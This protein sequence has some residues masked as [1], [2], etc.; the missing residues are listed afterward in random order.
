MVSSTNGELGADD[1]TAGYSNAPITAHTEVEVVDETKYV[2]IHT[3]I[4]GGIN[5]NKLKGWLL[6]H[7]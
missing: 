1:P 5:D 3:H 2:F 4:T 6:P 7:S